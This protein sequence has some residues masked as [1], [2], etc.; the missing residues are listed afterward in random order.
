MWNVEGRWQGSTDIPL[1]DVGIKQAEILAKRLEKYPI[2]AVYTS[3]L[4][5][6]ALTAEASATRLGL[7]INYHDG[8]KEI[9]LGKWEGLGIWDIRKKY[10]AEF[11]NWENNDNAQVGMGI[12]SNYDAQMR[13]YAALLEIC[14]TEKRDT[15]IVSHG[16]MINRIMCLMLNIP[17]RHR[18]GFRIQNTGLCVLECTFVDDDPRFQVVTL[19]DF[20]HLLSSKNGAGLALTTF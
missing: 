5:R 9:C 14:E 16:G 20:S 12:E 19:N 2:Q 11:E 8:L 3:P 10:P 1:D 15:L 13:G 6:A 18:Q 17:L 7:E 4:G